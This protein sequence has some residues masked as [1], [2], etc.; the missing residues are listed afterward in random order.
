MT[1]VEVATKRDLSD[2]GAQENAVELRDTLL[3]VIAR[4]ASDPSVDVAK[5]ERLLE[6]QMTVMARSAESSFNQALARLQPRLPRITKNGAI[7]LKDGTTK[8]KYARYSDI[9]DAIMPLLTEEGFTISYSSDLVP[10][11]NLLK[12]TV[13]VRH[14]DGH[15]DSGSV[16]LPLADD[17]GAK[18]RVQGAGSIYSYGKR[19]ALS[20]YLNIVTEDE[21]DN[22]MQGAGLPIDDKKVGTILDLI[23]DIKDSGKTFNDDGFLKLM[24]VSRIEDITNGQYDTAISA[25]NQKRK[26]SQ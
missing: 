4:A 20:Q 19:Y 9:C 26:K 2:S 18:N 24:K 8:I 22:G 11:G 14:I 12:I 1:T 21:D 13:T 10:A 7:V 3:G 16:F 5:M 15:Q 17:T 25:L 23:A 6:M